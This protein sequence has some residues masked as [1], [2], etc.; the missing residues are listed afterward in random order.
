VIRDAAHA[1][2][3]AAGIADDRGEIGVKSGAN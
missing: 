3:F 2:A 1:I